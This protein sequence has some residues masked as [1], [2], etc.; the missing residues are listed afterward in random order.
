M[1]REGFPRAYE[2]LKELTRN[3]RK[4]TREDIYEFIESLDTNQ[5][6]DTV[7]NELHK[8][9]PFNYVGKVRPIV[10]KQINQNI[11]PK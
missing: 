9:T 5:I 6:N 7:K 8:L 10:D 4:I 1:K 3:N 11:I 2:K